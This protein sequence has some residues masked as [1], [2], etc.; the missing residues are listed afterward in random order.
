M[1][2][3][4]RLAS[5]FALLLLLAGCGGDSGPKRHKVSGTA[6]FDGQPIPEGDIQFLAADGK[7][8][9]DGGRIVDGKF[10]LEVTAGKQRVE[11][12]ATRTNPKELVPSGIEP[13]KMEP[14]REDYIP[15]RYNTDSTL[16]AEVTASGLN[17]S[18]FKLEGA[19]PKP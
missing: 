18:E 5:L 11:I 8:P 10:S 16:T 19:A 1:P 6:S 17:P 13:G 2:H 4:F 9:V 14:K 15:A 7:G 3:V 12:R